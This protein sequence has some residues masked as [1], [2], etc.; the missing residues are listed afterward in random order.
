MKGDDLLVVRLAAGDTVAEAASRAGV[1]RATACRRVADPE[2]RGRVAK[3]RAQTF[4]AA[5]NTCADGALEATRFLRQVVLD[6]EESTSGRLA[7]SRELLAHSLRLR[8]SVEMAQRIA[9]LEERL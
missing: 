8:E 4:E 2:F 5:L 3:A 9:A 7:A 6:E 1:S